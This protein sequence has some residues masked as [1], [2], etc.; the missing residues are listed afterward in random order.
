MPDSVLRL[1]RN[2]RGH[3]P[4]PAQAASRVMPSLTQLLTS[5]HRLLILDAASK[6]V[7]VGL[8]CAGSPAIWRSTEA[9][10]GTE[11]FANADALLKGAGL[12]VCDIGA[13]VFCEGP[14]SMLGIRI[15]AM[16]LRTWEILAPH[17][18]YAYQSLAVAGRFA[19]MQKAPRNFTV[20]AD[21]RRETWHC[22]PVGADGRMPALQRVA[23][24]AVPRGE[25]LMPE[26][27]RAWAPPPCPAAVCGYDLAEIFPAIANGGHFHR[28]AVPDAFQ[29]E[30]PKYK[31][32][33]AQIHRAATADRK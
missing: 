32:W 4:A 7:Q 28:V 9:E 13:F 31:K 16:A 14:G 19:W 26:N 17:P 8:L 24:A 21:A 2:H 12:K 1:E 29:H 11:V 6:R 18:I 3:L 15:V 10:A 27:F 23:A 25:V 5:H 33:S 20:I 22:Q 30:V